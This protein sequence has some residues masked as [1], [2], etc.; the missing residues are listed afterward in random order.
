MVVIYPLLHTSLCVLTKW[1]RHLGFCITYTSLLMKTWRSVFSCK[2]ISANN[3]L[4]SEPDLP[5]QVRP[6]A[7]ADRQAA[8]AVDAARPAHHGHLP[9]HLVSHI[10]NSRLGWWVG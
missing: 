1:S 8:A 2:P 5:G 4:Q 10:R 3:I 6:Q 9:R 7:E